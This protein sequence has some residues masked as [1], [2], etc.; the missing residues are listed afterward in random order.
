MHSSTQPG[1]CAASERKA[2]VR[3][4]RQ[5]SKKLTRKS[6]PACAGVATKAAACVQPPASVTKDAAS[7][8]NKATQWEVKI[9]PPNTLVAT[10]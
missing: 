5:S 4:G 3:M 1:A 2:T 10:A 9:P 6:Q 7:G 8:R